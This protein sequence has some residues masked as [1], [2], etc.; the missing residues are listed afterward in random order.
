MASPSGDEGMDAQLFRP[1]DDDGVVLQFSVRKDWDT[2]IK[3]TCKRLKETAPDVSMLIY[4]TNHTV[5][6]KMNKLKKDVRKEYGFFVDFRDQEWFLTQRNRSAAVEA[7]AEA[8]CQ[9]SQTHRLAMTLRC[10]DQGQ[11]LEDLEAKAAFVYLGLQW[12]DD[13]R[14]KGLTKLCFKRWCVQYSSTTTSESRMS[15]ERVEAQVAKLLP[16]QTRRPETP[17]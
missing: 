11:A 10:A 8:F 3:E 13:T 9:R 1:T 14:E 17:K 12:E 4:A 7:E 6:P 2:K 16:A 15:R 5:G